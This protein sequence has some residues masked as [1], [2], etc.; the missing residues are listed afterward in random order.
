MV[1]F[2]K[3]AHA[4]LIT[5]DQARELTRFFAGE[6]S[7]AT[8][9]APASA[10]P[11]FDL[12][13]MLWYAGALLIIG[14]MT[15]FTTLGFSLMGGGFLAVTGAIYAVVAVLIGHHL[16]TKKNLTI[17]GGLFITIAV[18]MTPLIVFGIQDM[19]GWWS[20]GARPGA[21]R[22]F[23]FWIKGGWVPM[24]IATFAAAYLAIRRYPFGFIA[25]IAAVALWYFA[26]DLAQFI[27]QHE[28]HSWE[29][30]RKLTMWF[31][32]AT[33]FFA[34]FVDVQQRKADYAFWLHLAGILGFW[35]GLTFQ[36]SNSE[37]AKFF[38]FLINVGL[39]LFALY[40]GRRVYAVFGALGIAVYLG[41][42]A[43]RVFKDALL[44]PFVLTLIGLGVIMLGLW[45]HK[46]AGRLA[47]R[48]DALLPD[49]L[50]RLRP[51]GLTG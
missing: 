11:K 47:A 39:I 2:Q 23:H 38:Y 46:N 40:L 43:N 49:R 5:A 17:P 31:G 9:P 34:W 42:L 15:W 41:D 20:D 13:H 37:L 8:A 25:F 19:M 7:L 45:Y 24:E 51:G 18:A 32:L 22:D 21:Y 12:A 14:A 28:D 6:L 44:F 50:K 30:R 48:F 27:A 10:K 35:C 16:W 26:M 33:I 36:S 3:A 4:G 29:L 1:D